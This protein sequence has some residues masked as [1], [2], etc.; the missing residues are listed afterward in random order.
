MKHALVVFG[1]GA[2][3]LTAC[4]GS[5]ASSSA[6]SSPSPSTAARADLAPTGQLRMGFPM[7]PP[8]LGQRDASSGQWKGLAISIGQAL[9]KKLGVPLVPSQYVGPP[10][11]Y[12]A[13]QSGQVDVV[14]AQ[15]QMSMMPPGMT[16]TGAV[17]SVEHTYLVRGDSSLHN[18]SDVDRD[19]IKVG[20][21]A[22]DGHTPFLVSNLKHAQLLKFPSDDAGMAALATGKIDA[23]AD[24]RFALADLTTQLAG[25]RILDGS[26]LTPMFAF[27]ALASHTSGATFLNSFV[28]TELSGGDVKRYIDA[29][30]GKP[31]VIAGPEN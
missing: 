26:F 23:W 2:M 12:Q 17:V 3:L 4:G 5:G 14:F 24:G 6:A 21:N 31:G 20:S 1:A 11:T 9:A 15:V 27:T 19:G 8:F 18:V 7:A 30:V 28:A 16:S 10:Q 25:S 13:L 29:I 22:T